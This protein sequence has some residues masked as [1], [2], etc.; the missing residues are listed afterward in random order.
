[1]NTQAT[2]FTPAQE[3]GYVQLYAGDGKGKTTASVG[4]AI[5]AAARGWRVLFTQF[6]KDGNSAELKILEA[7]PTVDVISGQAINKFSFAMTDQEKAKTKEEME[8][9][10]ADLMNKVEH[11]D[12]LVLDEAVNAVNCYLLDEDLLLQFL[13]QR[14]AHLEVVLTGRNPSD[15]LIDQA[16]YYTEMCMRKHPYESEGLIARPGIEY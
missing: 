4:L 15:R 10:L 7:Q 14:P 1:M 12:L 2:D 5:R 11:Y 6:L 13:D 8:K 9:R 16:D 3:K